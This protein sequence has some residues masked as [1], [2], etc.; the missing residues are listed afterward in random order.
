MKKALIAMLLL[1]S[2]LLVSCT[3][4][5]DVSSVSDGSD[6]SAETEQSKEES[7]VD[8]IA[9]KRAEFKP[10]FR[11][12]AGSDV[13]L[14]AYSTVQQLRLQQMF[15]TAYAY[16]K[17]SSYKKVDAAIFAGDITDSCTFYEYTMFKAVLDNACKDETTV[18]T[19]MGNHDYYGGGQAVYMQSCDSSLD[20]D[21]VV[22]GYHFIGLSTY[23]DNLY[24]SDQLQ[25]LEQTMASAAES[26]KPIFTFQ[27]HHIKDTVYVSSEWYANQS[28]EL[29]AIYSK[30]SQCINFSGHSHGPINNPTSLVQTD[31]TLVGT[32]TLNYF[33]MTSGMTYGT[34]P[35]NSQDAAQYWIVEVGE[36]GDILLKPYNLLTGDF[37]KTADGSEY[38]E[39][40]IADPFDKETFAYGQ[41]RLENN[42]APYF[43]QDYAITVSEITKSSACITINQAK[44][45]YC[46]YSYDIKCG[47]KTYSYFSEYYFEPMPQT[48]SFDLTMLTAG[49]EYTVTVTPIDA[50]YVKGEAITTVFSTLPS[51][52]DFVAKDLSEAGIMFDF[53][54]ASIK[55]SQGNKVYGGS[56]DGDYWCGDWSSSIKTG[57]SAELAEGKG[58][59][60]T[61]ALGVTTTA[62]QNQG[63][64]VFGNYD[65][66]GQKYLIMYADFSQVDFRKA[67]FGLFTSD[68]SLYDTDENDYTA[69]QH[70]YYRPTDG[71]DWYTFEHGTD[72]CFGAAQD[73]SVKG[74]KG[75]F[76]FPIGDFGY[77]YGTGTNSGLG[78]IAGVYMYWDFDSTT[79]AG[80]YFYLDEIGFT[81]DYTVY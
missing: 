29:N 35:P 33:E 72:G 4:T 23:A 37:F 50:F 24:T 3:G 31:Y 19:V 63:L 75:V 9:Q 32:G 17:T 73:S 39:Y 47:E 62:K 27:H 20:K 71:T 79:P 22:G 59:K 18:I 58:Y 64:Y 41:K 40:Y 30:Y 60:G 44:D 49:T 54:V 2:I 52:K 68:G 74:L 57:S 81:N 11:F 15:E 76:A 45:D 38:L 77:R 7:T 16:A 36:A 25:W 43:E 66:T 55:Q 10:S 51:D 46:V 53:E 70:F 61:K 65:V 14:N 8:I 5:Q 67:C 42:E 78:K 26:G 21:I 1:V 56:I 69:N 28:A 6:A 12:I 48:L 13:H 80:T 34:I